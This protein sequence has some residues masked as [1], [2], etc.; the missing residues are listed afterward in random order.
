MKLPT[1]EKTEY[2]YRGRIIDV[3]ISDV[4]TG[5]GLPVK[6]EMVRHPGGAGALP[7]FDDG[8]VILVRQYRYPIGRLSLEIP[9]G[10]IEHGQTR[11]ETAN[12]ELEEEVGYVASNLELISEFFPNSRLL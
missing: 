6:I 10:R 9:A 5:S 11:Q 2:L 3:T 1:I 8:S 7:L 12:R 4:L